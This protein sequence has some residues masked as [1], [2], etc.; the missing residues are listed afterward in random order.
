M[1]TLLLILFTLSPCV[2]LAEDWTPPDNPDPQ[3]IL[4]EAKTDAQAG[5]HEVALAK[6][7]WYHDNALALQPAQSAVRLSFALS[8]WLELGEVYPPALVKMKQVRDDVEKRIRDKDQVRVKFADFHEF[9]AFNRTLREEQRTV[10]TFMWL[11]ETNHEDAKRVFHV[12]DPALIKLKEYKLCGKFIDSDDDIKRIG[13]NYERGLKLA[14]DRFGD[15]HREFAEKKF[16]NASTTLVALLVQ[17]DLQAEAEKT[18]KK[19]K[20]FVTDADLQTKLNQRLDSAL[21]GKV[22]SPWP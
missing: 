6:H 21:E 12:A 19:A 17:N 8:H 3:A 1:R 22:P 10:D 5:R 13:E 4:W 20:G 15:Q 9:V 11:D 18:A 14:I 2:C 7:I 16:L